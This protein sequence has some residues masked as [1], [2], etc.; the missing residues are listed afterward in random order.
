[1]Y[2]WPGYCQTLL[3]SNHITQ[4]IH[5]YNL[6][7]CHEIPLFMRIFCKLRYGR[8][9]SIKTNYHSR[10]FHVQYNEVCVCG[11]KWN[12]YDCDPV[13][14]SESNIWI[15]SKFGDTLIW[16]MKESDERFRYPQNKTASIRFFFLNLI[17]SGDLAGSSTTAASLPFWGG[18]DA[19]EVINWGAQR[20]GI[21]QDENQGCQ[22]QVIS[23]T[24]C[25]N[26]LWLQVLYNPSSVAC[27]Y[28]YKINHIY[29]K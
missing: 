6:H 13:R 27:I 10:T 8:T 1:M 24:S 14:W 19:A 21:D 22:W 5:P 12:W 4:R 3:Q 17:I 18:T 16:I 26:D 9:S 11:T 7:T 2:Y 15:R 20:T 28:V 29:T 25:W 23:S